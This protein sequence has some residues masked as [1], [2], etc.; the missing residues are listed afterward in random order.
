MG[1]PEKKVLRV[2]GGDQRAEGTANAVKSVLRR[3][4]QQKDATYAERNAMAA[5]FNKETP[6]LVA[7][8]KGVATF[9]ASVVDK[10]N[11]STYWSQ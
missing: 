10:Q 8:S 4:N 11:P 5:A 6:G 1:H 7:L 9:L 3:R 2:K